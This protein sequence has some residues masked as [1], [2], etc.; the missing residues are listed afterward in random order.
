VACG[1]VGG[2]VVAPRPTVMRYDA[3]GSTP[4]RVEGTVQV[5]AGAGTGAGA[6]A[7]LSPGVTEPLE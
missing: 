2:R 6:R 3:E 5:Q 1:L 7:R 4:A